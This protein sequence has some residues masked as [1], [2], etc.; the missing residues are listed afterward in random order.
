MSQLLQKQFDA[1]VLRA[2]NATMADVSRNAAWKMY[3]EK[4]N[5]LCKLTVH[6]TET[7]EVIIAMRLKHTREIAKI[8]AEVE[9]VE[10]FANEQL[11]FHGLLA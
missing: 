1:T 8:F 5:P 7:G 2:I 3:V 9:D 10:R 11:E 6:A 4:V